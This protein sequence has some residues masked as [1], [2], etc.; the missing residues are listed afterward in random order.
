MLKKINGETWYCCPECGQK[1]HPVKPG[2]RGVMVACKGK[3]K[4]G[5]R[6][7]W[8]GEIRWDAAIKDSIQIKQGA[9]WY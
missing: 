2:A 8:T 9:G 5:T 7:T 4:D 6:C 1:I 3:K